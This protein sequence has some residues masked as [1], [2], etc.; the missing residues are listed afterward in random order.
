MKRMIWSVNA[1]KACR[2]VS[3]QCAS[4]LRRLLATSLLLTLSGMSGAAVA[5]EL[6]IAVS[7]SPLSLLF[8][9]AESRGYFAAEGVQVT[10][11]EAIGGP[12]AMRMLADGKAD[13]ATSSDT[14]VMFNSFERNDFA[15]IATFGTNNKDVNF[16][17]GKALGDAH[18][19]QLVGKR[20]GMVVASASHYFADSWLIFHGVDPKLTR[21]V[22]LQPET[23]ATALA[24]GEVDAVAIWDPY[25]FN[26]LKTV[27]GTK[28]LPNPGIYNLSFNLIADRKLLGTRDDELASVLRALLRAEHDVQAEPGKAQAI[29]RERLK[30]DQDFIDWMWPNINYRVSLMPSLLTTLESEARWAR[31][32][33][34]VTA[35]RSPN[36]L[37]FIYSEPLRK[38][39][40]DRIGIGR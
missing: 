39:R 10:L 38:A 4:T 28:L 15:V 3:E 8:F 36:Y 9:V 30:L 35:S 17:A 5:A 16:I 23:M 11:K 25:S 22:S 14:V 6:T 12:R 31:Q 13:L 24:K 40:P 18:P 37:N 34:H 26:I 19:K 29:L 32:E 27:P 7:R 1:G 20:I 33:G 21:P 2:W